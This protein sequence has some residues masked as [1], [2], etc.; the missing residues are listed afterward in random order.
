MAILPKSRKKSIYKS[1]SLIVY[2]LINSGACVLN[3]KFSFGG[4]HV[5]SFLFSAAIEI[6]WN[7]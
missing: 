4:N 5:E 3:D 2:G 1:D 7:N 6:F